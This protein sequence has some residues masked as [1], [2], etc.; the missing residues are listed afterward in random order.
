MREKWLENY[1]FEVKIVT[2]EAS[3]TITFWNKTV[4]M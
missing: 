3:D 1:V 2:L 4:L